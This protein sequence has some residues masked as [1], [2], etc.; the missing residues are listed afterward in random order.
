[1]YEREIER[2][3]ADFRELG[4]PEYVPRMGSVHLAPQIVSAI[5]GARRSGKSY[6]T[7]QVADEMIKTGF[8]PSIKHV[9]AIDFDNPVLSSMN[10]ADL[11]LIQKVFLK[12]NAGFTLK[13]PILFI[14]DELHKITGWEN[15]VIDL[16]RN[17]NWRVLVTG[18]SSKML[19]EEVATELRG[20]AVT[21]AVYPLTFGE[22]V[23]FHGSTGESRSTGDEALLMRLFDEYLHWGSYPAMPAVPAHMKE[24]VLRQYFDTM[25][26]RDIIQRYEVPKPGACIAAMRHGVAN[27]GKPFTVKSLAAYVKEAGHAVGRE[28]VTDY[29]GW[30]KD[31]W[32]LFAVPIYSAS[33]KEQERN[34]KKL[35][36]ID[37][38][39]AQHNSASW[40]GAYSRAFE[41]MVFLHLKQRFSRVH[42]CLTREKRQEVD[43][44]AVDHHGKAVS[45]VQAC[46]DIG[47]K[48]TLKREIEPLVSVARYY[49]CRENIIVTYG[50]EKSFMVDGFGIRAVPAWRWLLEETT[51]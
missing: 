44:I 15:Y 18:S 32:L 1:M 17:R 16:S 11:T 49:G 30:A 24:A 39:L 28:T 34:Y 36:C 35:Y 26:L 31:A 51:L 6:R 8:L 42:F 10:A 27:M 45:A 2:K 9:C 5:I 50:Q 25:I 37:W 29:L 43:F 19:H 22:F 40:D 4:L 47:D 41:N 48:E 14:L 23:S 12:I 13:T 3:I 33:S 46:M 38:A 20:K 7:M 21:S